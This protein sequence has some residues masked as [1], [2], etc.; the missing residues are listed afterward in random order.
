[1][2]KE[3]KRHLTADEVYDIVKKRVSH[4]SLGTVYR[5]LE[6]LV[7]T[8]QA[9]KIDLGEGKRRFDS[10][11]DR[12]HHFRCLRCGRVY[13]VPY[14]PLDDIKSK[15]LKGATF[16]ITDMQVVL[17]GIC[18]TCLEKE[19]GGKRKKLSEKGLDET[20]K[21]VLQVLSRLEK[22]AGNREIA[23][24]AGLDG[25]EVTKTLKALK[26]KGLVNSPVR[27]KYAATKSGKLEAL[28]NLKRR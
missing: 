25:K 12:H 10:R 21:N 11:T 16:K 19:K 24:A 5:N 27:C 8:G 17:E 13:N 3:A 2:L 7:E 22:P 9:S 20:Q 14:F 26:S 28:N 4:I 23:Q 1:M 6:M 15:V 18:E